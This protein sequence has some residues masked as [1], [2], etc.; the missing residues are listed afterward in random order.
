MKWLNNLFKNKKDTTVETSKNY[1][2]DETMTF[3]INNKDY[4]I[5]DSQLI[6]IQAASDDVKIYGWSLEFRYKDLRG[7]WYS[8]STYWNNRIYASRSSALQAAT[9]IYPSYREDYEFRVLP[10]YK[11]NEPEYREYKIHQL[12]NPNRVNK[13]PESYEL[14][15]WKMTQDL[16]TQNKFKFTKDKT[17]FIQLENGSIIK[18]G[19]P[20][21]GTITGFR[22]LLFDELIPNG[23]VQEIELKDEKWLYPH[24]LKELK[25]KIR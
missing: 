22:K 19:G 1:V 23:M 8:W 3:K 15:A 24:L 11:M 10:L 6:K 5:A 4:A 13:E 9:K 14:K 21:E 20:N 7:G 12:I 25:F 2:N 16:V 17:V 18:S